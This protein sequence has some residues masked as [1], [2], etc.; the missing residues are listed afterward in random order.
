MSTTLLSGFNNLLEQFLEELVQTFPELTDL[1]TVQMLVSIMRKANPRMILENFLA[2]TG[3]YHEK[4]FAEES[5]FFEDL[6]NWKQDPT[7]QAEFASTEDEQN[8]M[9][10][11][12]VVFKDVWVDLTPQNKEHIW[13]YMQQLIVMGAQ[14]SKSIHPNLCNQIIQTALRYRERR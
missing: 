10:Q 14:A 11:R 12:L 8:E 13:T 1:K 9:F 3:K 4:I 2:V 5:S 6:E 7:F